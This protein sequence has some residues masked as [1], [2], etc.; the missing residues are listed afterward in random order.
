MTAGVLA[1][2]RVATE[3]RLESSHGGVVEWSMP[4]RNTRS[5]RR[6][7]GFHHIYNRTRFGPLF[8]D[9]E[10]R[11]KFLEIFE[12][13][14]ADGRRRDRWG[15]EYPRLSPA[16]KLVT[17][18]LMSNHFHLILFQVI[19]GGVENLMRRVNQTYVRYFR[20]RHGGV[21]P[22]F[23]GEYRS[24]HK[25][26][27]RSQL[28]AIAYVHDNHG[29]DCRCEFCGHRY[30]D[31]QSIEP[32]AYIDIDRG[33]ALFGGREGYRRFRSARHSLRDVTGKSQC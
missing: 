12:R 21:G 24:D 10:D 16:V 7:L 15:R 19:P 20:E 18:A 30:F 17:F 5:R 2:R 33:V 4:R 31:D 8:V 6:R 1:C 14:L 3:I 32:P 11:R 23:A 29:D 26:D 13:Y 27:R 28:T 9:D 25:R 22:M